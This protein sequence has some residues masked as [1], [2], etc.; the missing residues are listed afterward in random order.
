MKRKDDIWL[1]IT[2]FWIAVYQAP[3]IYWNNYINKKK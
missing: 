2:T 1:Q 3:F